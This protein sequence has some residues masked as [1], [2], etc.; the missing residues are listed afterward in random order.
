MT[1]AR[2]RKR[3][4]KPA[5]KNRKVRK[6]SPRWGLRVLLV[7]LILL[8]SWVV[9]LDVTVRSQFEGRRWQ[10]PARIFSSPLMLYEGAALATGDLE[11]YLKV[12]GYERSGDPSVPGT[13]RRSG[14]SVDLYLRPFRFEDGDQPARRI[15]LE[16]SGGQ[17]VSL[18]AGGQSLVR[19]EPLEIGRFY[20][21]SREDRILV[22]RSD[23]PDT[24][25]QA[26]LL[27]EDRDFYTHFGI[28]LKGI[29]RAAWANITAGRVVQGG[30]TLTQQLVKNFYL[31]SERTFWRKLNEVVMA[32]LLD[33]HYD[34]DTILEAYA[35]EVYLGQSGSIAVHGF[36]RASLFWFGKP[37]SALTLEQQALLVAM[38]RGPAYYHPARHPDRARARRN[39]VLALLGEAGIVAP[40]VVRQA[41][42][43]PLG[44]TRNPRLTDSLYPHY[45]QLVRRQLLEFYPEEVL[46]SEGLRIFTPLNPALQESVQ[47][48]V[49]EFAG[50]RKGLQGAVVMTE[51]ESGE[52][53][54]LVGDVRRQI[55]GFNRALDAQRQ[56]GSLI[57]P[58]IL[59]TALADP[60]RYTLATLVDD[61]PFRLEFDDGQTWSPENFDGKSL[62]PILL[63]EA[64]VRSRNQAMVRVGLD[65]G[66][67]RVLESMRSAGP[68]IQV[69]PW[70]AVLL[71]AVP[72]SPLDVAR[73]YTAIAAG[74]VA[75]PLRSI[76]AVTDAQGNL[77]QSFDYKPRAVIPPRVAYLIQ[78][79]LLDVMQRGTG[80]SAYRIFPRDY[81]VAGKTGTTN[82]GRDSWF[83]GYNGRYLGV[84]WLGHDDNRPT[85]LTGASGAL[86]VWLDV[87]RRLPAESFVMAQPEG[88]EWAWVDTRTGKRLDGECEH[89]IQLPFIAGSMPQETV[90]C[91]S[92]RRSLGGWLKRWFG[93]E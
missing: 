89:G 90:A 60:G 4:Q 42:S 28:S 11:Q 61:T 67:S 21:R 34:K 37:L 80:A 75:P 65:V 51:R 15:H 82:D 45:V 62:G 52:V 70:P 20:P 86:Q 3:P 6:P 54:A 84:V 27:T 50:R 10:V 66:V 14:N 49:S 24:L 69:R 63:E 56:I 59:V 39:R 40:E 16:V 78:T 7:T 72:L 79:A 38:I 26:L 23:L 47:R 31:S 30:S 74:G 44:I 76:R 48:S 41:Q 53:V 83:A 35:N 1:R 93:G 92:G 8:L 87:Y 68:E 32:L 73:L 91:Q 55:A 18:D 25:V 57:K 19:V 88:I 58:W 22:S 5:G 71:G 77:L 12:L 13:W 33:A 29:A 17:V 81:Y 2:K 64:L 36:G 9:W 85:G 43:R 46:E